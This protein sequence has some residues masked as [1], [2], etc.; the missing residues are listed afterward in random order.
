AAAAPRAS[1][2]PGRSGDSFRSAVR[3]ARLGA[4]HMDQLAIAARGRPVGAGWLLG[5]VPTGLPR[6]RDRLAP[7]SPAPCRV[8]ANGARVE[9]IEDCHAC[10]CGLATFDPAMSL[11]DG[12]REPH[13][14]DCQS[15]LC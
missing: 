6:G 4:G 9:A 10:L 14:E 15:Y 13:S 11:Q 1:R 12:A 2:V 8:A 7:R 5:A 3:A